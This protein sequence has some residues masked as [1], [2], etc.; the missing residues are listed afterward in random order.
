MAKNNVSDWPDYD[1]DALEETILTT[2]APTG[3]VCARCKK[4]IYAYD[5]YSAN[6]SNQHPDVPV[7]SICPGGDDIINADGDEVTLGAS[8]N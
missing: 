1:V 3:K 7:H 2:R 4:P 5:L 8:T 6:G